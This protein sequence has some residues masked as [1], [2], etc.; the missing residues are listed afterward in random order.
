MKMVSFCITCKNRLHQIRQTLRKNLSDNI[1]H[2]DFIEFILVDFSSTDGLFDWIISNFQSE[3]T[4]G[5][6]KYYYTEALPYWHASIANDHAFH[7]RHW[8]DN[9][10]WEVVSE[11]PK[12]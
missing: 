2:Q 1:M 3:M 10:L 12:S 8:F 5:Y 4:S 7:V 9:P 11:V 6:L